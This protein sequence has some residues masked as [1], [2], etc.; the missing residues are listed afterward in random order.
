MA[1]LIAQIVICLLIAAA[2][3]FILGWLIRGLLSSNRERELDDKWTT[4][5]TQLDVEHQT[6][7]AEIK[8]LTSRLERFE[9]QREPLADALESR[10]DTHEVNYAIENLPGVDTELGNKLRALGITSASE[11]RER[12]S[13]QSAVEA[14]A[15]ATEVRPEVLRQCARTAD[16][17]RM[18]AINPAQATLLEAAGVTSI[19]VLA[20]QDASALS[21]RITRLKSQLDVADTTDTSTDTLSKW[22]AEATHLG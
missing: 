12:C 3:G 18:T 1:H 8:S 17:L 2:I 15:S 4:R 11:L 6:S 10:T 21:A 5:L 14:L 20:Q 7:N 16:L 13:S 22:I 19:E 9:M